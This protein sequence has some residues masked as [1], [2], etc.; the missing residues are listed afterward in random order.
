MTDFPT[1]PTSTDQVPDVEVAAPDTSARRTPRPVALAMLT[2]ST[3]AAAAAGVWAAQTSLADALALPVEVKIG[4]GI[5]AVL[6]I[7]LLAWSAGSVVAGLVADRGARDV[8]LDVA[9]WVV[10]LI[11][12]FLAAAGQ[13]AFAH[14]AGIEGWTAYLVP[15]ILEPSVVVLLLLANR[16]VQKAVAGLPTKPIGKLMALAALLGGFAVYTN[17]VHSPARSGLVFGAATVIGLILWWVKL[18]D[19]AGAE[20]IEDAPQ[21]KR[22]S[23]R[24]ARYR[25]LRWIIL[26][27]QTLRAWLISLDHSIDDAE[28]GL[29]LARRWRRFYNESRAAGVGRSDARRF[30]TNG[31][32]EYM[33]ARARTDARAYGRTGAYAD[34]REIA[35]EPQTVSART[36][37]DTSQVSAAL[38]GEPPAL[39]SAAPAATPAARVPLV[40][41]PRRPA[42][43]GRP[44]ARKAAAKAARPAPDVS[45]LMPAGRAVRD[46]LAADGRALT[47]DAL[48][49]GLRADGVS[50]SSER[51]SA[52]L[53]ALNHEP[54]PAP[55]LASA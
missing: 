29:E 38:V 36:E 42:S 22:L 27:R 14:W 3:V 4:G 24:T 41:A 33:H 28:R 31:V 40:R 34:A 5:A 54:H 46:R 45:D 16:R 15:G 48:L 10:A 52:L 53:A 21:S 18:Q 43:S 13:V 17:V 49:A 32:D 8:A 37:A 9:S 51:A 6:V 1:L 19:T 44:P 25:I 50:C 35:A 39:P 55:A 20:L 47:R 26:P 30:A 23:R 11:A 7:V 2:L 12:G